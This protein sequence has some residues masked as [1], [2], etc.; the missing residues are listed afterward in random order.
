MHDRNTVSTT[1]RRTLLA[2]LALAAAVAAQ[3]APPLSIIRPG[4]EQPIPFSHK[5]H[6][7][8]GVECSVCHPM[9]DPGV[10]AEIAET[11]VC[12]SCHLEVKTDSPAIQ[13]LAEAH[14][15]GKRIDWAPVYMV[16]DF[17][18]FSHRQHV[19]HEGVTCA[20]CHGDVA[21]KDV[22][23]KEINLSMAGCMACHRDAGASVECDYC[24]ETRGAG[25]NR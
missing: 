24:H 8:Q 21:S 1:W 7:A 19:N 12:M 3:Q 13:K 18:F 4:P 20:S 25:A 5:T 14:R 9:S 11:Q 6:A 10:F 2:G 22:V 17:V 16:A 23:A 15:A